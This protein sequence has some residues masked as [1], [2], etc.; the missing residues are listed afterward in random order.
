MPDLAP[1]LAT[2]FDALR[3]VEM[4]GARLFLFKEG[5]T[6]DRRLTPIVFD[7]GALPGLV[8]RGWRVNPRRFDRFGAP[9]LEV[10]IARTRLYTAESLAPVRGFAL[11]KRGQT[12]GTIQRC[13][14]SAVAEFATEPVWKFTATGR[15]TETH[16]A[17]SNAL[18]LVDGVTYLALANGTDHL[19]LH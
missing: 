5:T 8:S 11:V 12:V 15:T 13:A 3:G 7:A 10:Q 4:P 19:R 1:I 9:F 6:A 14:P 2:K 16:H 17:D 18:L